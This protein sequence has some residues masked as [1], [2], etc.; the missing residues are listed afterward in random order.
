MEGGRLEG[1]VNVDMDVD[2]YMKVGVEV[3]SIKV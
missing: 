2:I 1:K 3:G